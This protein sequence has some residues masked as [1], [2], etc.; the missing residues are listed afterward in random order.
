MHQDTDSDVADPRDG[1][2]VKVKWTQDEVMA[3]TSCSSCFS[4]MDT[5]LNMFVLAG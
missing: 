5:N 1:W 3:H 2:K 4:F